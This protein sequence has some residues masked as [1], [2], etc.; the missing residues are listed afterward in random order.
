MKAVAIRAVGVPLEIIEAKTPSSCGENEVVIRNRAVGVNFIDTLIQDG[1]IPESMMPSLP[2][3]PGVEGCGEVVLAGQEVENVAVGDRVAWF[4][5][6]ESHGYAEY[7]RVA[8]EYVVKTSLD[9][10][11]AAGVPVA[12]MTAWHLLKNL[13]LL[14]E[15][16]WVVIRAAAG[17]VG[18]ALLQLARYLKYRPI[19]IASREK[20]EFCKQNGAVACI[21]RADSI[22]EKI[23]EIVSDEGVML[24]LNSVGGATVVEDCDILSPFGQVILYGFLAGPPT[25]SLIETVVAHFQK[26]IAIRASDIYTLYRLDPKAF[27]V[28]LGAVF[29]LLHAGHIQ[30]PIVHRVAP[31]DQA[32]KVHS[33]L[34][35][36]QSRGKLV[37]RI[38]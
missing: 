24:C 19:A 37:I 4:G 18:S 3:V 15:N 35:S 17:G 31:L 11:R 8:C 16:D 7:S 21:D 14:R 13:S 36:G 6:L 28:H 26:S 38:D 32:E 27:S 33:L 2:H 25:A 5:T 22:P 12:Y 23:K 10:E 9:P 29:D 34:K 20:L 30:P 1:K